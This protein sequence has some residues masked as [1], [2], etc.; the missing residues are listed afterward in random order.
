MTKT[1][2]RNLCLE[3]SKRRHTCCNYE[4]YIPLLIEDMQKIISLDYPAKDC[5]VVLDFSERELADEEDWW[6]KG[7]VK[8]KNRYY[9]ICVLSKGK[10]GCFFLEN[11]KGCVLTD[12]RPAICKLYPFWFDKNMKLTYLAD[13]CDAYKQ[14]IPLADALKIMGENKIKVKKYFLKLQKDFIKNYPIY[15]ELTKLLI[16]KKYTEFEKKL[17]NTKINS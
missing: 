16:A 12:K 1:I 2:S 3:C 15:E 10:D 8:I 4:H 6:K 11:E 17:K 13:Y 7:M 9:K 5:L 14:K